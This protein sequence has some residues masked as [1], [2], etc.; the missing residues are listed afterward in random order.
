MRF[1]KSIGIVAVNK[2]IAAVDS[3]EWQMQEIITSPLPRGSSDNDDDG[4]GIFDED[5]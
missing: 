5:S 1:S 3:G 4:L 2:F